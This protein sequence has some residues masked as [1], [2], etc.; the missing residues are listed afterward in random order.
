GRFD[1]YLALSPAGCVVDNWECVRGTSNVYPT[2]PMTDAQVS[3]Y[4]AQGF[5]V[6]IHVTLDPA[7]KTG[8]GVDFT[9]ATLPA[10]YTTQ[11]AQFGTFFPSAT[12]VKTH[13]IHCL[14]WSD[15][16]TQAQVELQN[17]IRLDTN[18]YYWPPLWIQDRPGMFTGS[19]M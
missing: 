18:Y 9:A 13:R 11:L 4:V 3:N 2:T 17:G 16:L 12:P 7:T 19:G 14:V 5:E 15:W 10:F 1:R 8:C 6:G